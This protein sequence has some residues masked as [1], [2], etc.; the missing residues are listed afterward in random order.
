MSESIA[1]SSLL[2]PPFGV[3]FMRFAAVLKMKWQW[4]IFAT[5]ADS[6]LKMVDFAMV[7]DSVVLVCLPARWAYGWNQVEKRL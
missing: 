2:S 5:G 7:W 1:M 4:Q 3:P 6:P